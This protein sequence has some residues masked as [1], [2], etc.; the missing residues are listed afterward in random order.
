MLISLFSTY[1]LVPFFCPLNHP[2]FFTP[3]FIASTHYF[4]TTNPLKLISSNCLFSSFYLSLFPFSASISHFILSL[5]SFT[6]P[7]FQPSFHCIYLTLDFFFIY[8]QF[9]FG[10][11]NIFLLFL[12]FLSFSV[13]IPLYLL[14]TISIFSFQFGDISPKETNGKLFNVT[15]AGVGEEQNRSF[16]LNTGC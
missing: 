9:T 8:D 3:S 16:M 1:F 11:F 14:S 7:L 15:E 5:P 10:S 2:F 4:T 12:H 13:I 6:S